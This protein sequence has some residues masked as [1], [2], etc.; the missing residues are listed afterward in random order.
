MLWKS[1]QNR[2]DEGEKTSKQPPYEHAKVT[3]GGFGG[4]F[5]TENP[6]CRAQSGP[7]IDLRQFR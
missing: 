2:R 4:V 1:C 3:L 5:E 7:R 6:S